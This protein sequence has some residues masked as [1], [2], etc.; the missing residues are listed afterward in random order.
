MGQIL[1]A[2]RLI[3]IDMFYDGKKRGEIALLLRML[4]DLVCSCNP[5]Y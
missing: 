5:N 1:A 2:H 4:L 3:I